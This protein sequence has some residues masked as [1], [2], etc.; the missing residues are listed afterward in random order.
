MGLAAGRILVVDDDPPLLKLVTIYL[1][2][3]GYSVVSCRSAEEAWELV[4]AAPSGYALALVDLNMPGMRG[5][6]L[7]H[8]ILESNEAI[9]VI[10]SSGYPEDLSRVPDLAGK[11]VG[12]LQKPFTPHELAEAVGAR[13]APAA[14]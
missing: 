6:E 3:L 9:Q 1:S 10:V 14:G 4:R 8:R 13:V 2:R 11:R 7:A 12:F 5:E